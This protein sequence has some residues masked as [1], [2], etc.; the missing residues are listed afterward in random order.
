MVEHIV[1]FRWK[2]GTA[3][4]AVDRV[5]QELQGLKLKISGILELTCGANFSD[6]AQGF[7]HGLV[8]RLADR[9]ALDSYGPHPDHQRV[10]QQFIAPIR[11]TTLAMDYEIA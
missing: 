8:V 2:P 3:P 5:M 1:L 7:T 11:D 6:R 4:E 10:V 9:A